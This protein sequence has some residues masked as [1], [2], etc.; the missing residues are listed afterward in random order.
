[1]YCQKNEATT[2]KNIGNNIY[3]KEKKK[4]NMV[5]KK[6][7]KKKAKMAHELEFGSP[8][9]PLR[10]KVGSSNHIQ[11]IVYFFPLKLKP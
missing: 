3:G 11:N 7:K 1:M 5:G 2:H 9:N 6:K 10:F 8:Y 4:K